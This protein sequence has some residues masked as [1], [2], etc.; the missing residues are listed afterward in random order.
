MTNFHFQARHKTEITTLL[1]RSTL[2]VQ[3]RVDIGPGALLSPARFLRQGDCGKNVLVIAQRSTSALFGRQ[4][5]KALK[6]LDLQVSFLEVPDG[7]SAKSSGQLLAVWE[8][9]ESLSFERGDTII[10]LGGGAVCDLS[11]FAASTY[12]RGVRLALIP[13]TLLSQVDAAIGG[14]T[15]INLAAGKNLA[16]TFYF[17]EAVFVDPEV[18]STLPEREWL[19][20]MGEIIKY[21]LIEKTV[22]AQ[23]EYRSG[24]RPLFAVL[25]E[26]LANGIKWDAP[27]MQGIIASCIKM[28]LAVVGKDPLEKHLRRSLN[29]GHTLAHA[30]ETVSNYEIAHGQAVAIGLVFAMSLA[31][32]F[33]RCSA[34]MRQSVVDLLKETGLPLEIPSSYNRQEILKAMFQDKKRQADRLKFV[35]PCHEIGQVDIDSSIAFDELAALL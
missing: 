17:P 26:N 9:L 23:A 24:P 21:A 7:E 16:G 18:L 28:K 10:A 25:Q 22:S 20:G 30:L 31:V 29:L 12:L 32:R 1:F 6:E 4:L 5:T 34:A 19:S 35:L 15:A 8:K 27:S 33:G 2:P 13:T 3:G 14:K 11:G